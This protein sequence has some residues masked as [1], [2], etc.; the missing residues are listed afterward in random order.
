MGAS[1]SILYTLE[2]I[3][4][5]YGP[6]LLDLSAYVAVATG[7]VKELHILMTYSSQHQ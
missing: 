1:E 5:E 7:E 6:C 3:K 4:K 2:S